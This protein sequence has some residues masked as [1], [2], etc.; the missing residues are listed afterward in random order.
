MGHEPALKQKSKHPATTTDHPAPSN[1]DGLAAGSQNLLP[2]L[3]RGGGKHG[4][5]VVL[6][7]LFLSKG[8]RWSSASPSRLFSETL[9]GVEAD[10]ARIMHSGSSSN[11]MNYSCSNELGCSFS[12][13]GRALA[14]YY[15][16]CNQN[17]HGL[18]S[19]NCLIRAGSARELAISL[20]PP[21]TNVGRKC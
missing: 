3:Q 8:R 19:S 1:A 12:Q 9:A 21:S 6:S 2:N 14:A 10:L 11:A 20:T 5:E 13:D 17:H 16:L 15:L 4:K 7:S 18:A